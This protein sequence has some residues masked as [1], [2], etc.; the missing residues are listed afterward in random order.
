LT[1]G[2]TIYFQKDMDQNAKDIAGYE[3]LVKGT[4]HLLTCYNATLD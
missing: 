1:I 2:T 3:F 4:N